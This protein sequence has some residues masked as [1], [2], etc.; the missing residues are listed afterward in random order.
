[1]YWITVIVFIIDQVT[2]Y[3]IRASLNL[4]SGVVVI[5][6][7]FNIVHSR[8]KGAAFGMFQNHSQYLTVITFVAVFLILYLFITTPKKDKLLR[9]AYG[10]ILGGALGNLYDRVI[11]G[12]VTDFLDFHIGQ[13]SWPTFNVADSCISVA[14]VLIIYDAIRKERLRTHPVANEELQSPKAAE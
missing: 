14:I 2:K 12:Y 4:G 13:H 8:N 7:L 9:A 5:P 10:M 6:H 11:S 1:M 3:I